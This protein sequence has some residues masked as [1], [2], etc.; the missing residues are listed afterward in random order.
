MKQKDALTILKQGKN[1]LVTGAAGSGK[2]Y[3]LAEFVN[4]ARNEG[5]TVAVTATTGLAATH[6]NGR[7]IHNYAN[8]GIS[9]PKELMCEE[10]VLFLAKRMNKNYKNAVKK[11]DILVI[12][13][14]SMLA[15]CALD[16]V[17]KI[18]RTVRNNNSA[19]GGMQVVLCGDF[20]QLPP[21]DKDNDGVNFITESQVYKNECFSVCYLEENFR[22]NEKDPLLEILN[23]IRYDK[24]TDEHRAILQARAEYSPVEKAI[25]LYCK[26]KNVDKENQQELDN[27]PTGSK[28][29]RWIESGDKNELEKLKND[30]KNKVTEEVELKIGARVMFVKNNPRVG[31]NNG[32][33]GEVIAFEDDFPTV[34]L[35][36][37]KV[38]KK[39]QYDDFY[40]EDVN[41]VR[42]AEINQIPLKLAWA[43]TIHK[44]QGMTLDKVA[45]DLSNTF[46]TGQGYVALS[47]AKRLEDITLVGIINP[48]ALTVSQKALD[49]EQ[50]FQEKSK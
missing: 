20:F 7:T 19:F 21:I 41:G 42:V 48:M 2:T 30:L 11:T 14:V 22:Q 50:E 38:L 31:Y 35:T 29:Y 40:R 10:S 49:L 8:L 17:D 18:M 15:D 12:D 32:T 46:E 6:L 36:T 27:L 1:T 3:L 47:R 5:K 28:I 23:A 34:A 9:K 16:A 44:C 33:I 24:V 4:W 37:G 39:I 43:I 26:N 45:I 13:E 25:K